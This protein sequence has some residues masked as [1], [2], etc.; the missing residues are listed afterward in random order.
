MVY[1]KESLA[2]RLE[3]LREYAADI[4]EYGGVPF[5]V[6]VKD[7]KTKYSIERLL[8]LISE[9][10]LD[11]L[12]HILSSKHGVVSDSYED[13]ILN[14]YKKALL[15]DDL[16]GKLKGLGGFRN[17]IAHE[18]LELNDEE[19]HR[20]CQKVKNTLAQVISAFEKLI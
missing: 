13:I 17:I 11:F 8:L 20:N 10:V 4:G 9:N 16:Y 12:D 14:A 1:N 19:V 18:Y 7:K 15:D 5:E 2:K 6:Y 3:K